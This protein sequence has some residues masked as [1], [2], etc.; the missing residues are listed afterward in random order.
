[1]THHVYEKA[2]EYG[3]HIREQYDHYMTE[4][5][6][7]IGAMA[8]AAGA[9][10]GLAIPSTRYE[11]ELMGE[12]RENVLQRSQEALSGLADR[13]KRVANETGQTINKEVKNL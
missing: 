7:A 11:G 3:S 1:M 9:A 13:A 2:G 8:F 10:I 4:N 12:A 5:P 6:L